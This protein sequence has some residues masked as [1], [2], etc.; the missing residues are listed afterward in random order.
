MIIPTPETDAFCSQIRG[1]GTG[2]YQAIDLS[3]K[4]E[5]ERNEAL[6][7]LE[8]LAETHQHADALANSRGLENGKLRAV[9]NGLAMVLRKTNPDAH[10]LERFTDHAEVM[11]AL[12]AYDNLPHVKK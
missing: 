3:R 5:R 2:Y 1:L 7:E 4:L 12:A 8:L 9:A 6:K 11:E 10:L